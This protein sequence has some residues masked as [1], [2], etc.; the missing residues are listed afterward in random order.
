VDAGASI[1]GLVRLA[2]ENHPEIDAAEAKVRR[3]MAKVPQAKALPDPKMKISAGS[4]AETAAGRV[5]WMTGVE[6]AL[7]FPG[8]LRE[9]A[10][11][12]G[13]EAEAAAAMLEATR[14]EIAAQ[15]RRAYWNQY[16]AAETTAIT[17]DSRDA[18]K[19]I[20]NSVD[21]R[22]A[23]NQANQGDQLRLSTEIG[24]VEAALVRSR[25]GEGSARSRMNALLIKFIPTLALCGVLVVDG[26]QAHEFKCLV[27]SLGR[28]EVFK[29]DVD[30]QIDLRNRSTAHAAVSRCTQWSFCSGW[31]CGKL[32]SLL[33]HTE[34]AGSA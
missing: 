23:A 29:I 22:A 13:S 9:M 34:H 1:D 8:K 28:H 26:V 27:H 25:Q 14:L 4:M 33:G 24:K 18:L 10:R 21:A 7:P 15:V 11:A 30:K 31:D 17:A 6:Q 32:N 19:L 5:D 20:R 2:L 12:A 16:L 3:M